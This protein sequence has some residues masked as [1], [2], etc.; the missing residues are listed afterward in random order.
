MRTHARWVKHSKT[1]CSL[2]VPKKSP[3]H[4]LAH[5]PVPRCCNCH[6]GSDSKLPP[7]CKRVAYSASTHNVHKKHPKNTTHFSFLHLQFFLW[8]YSECCWFEGEKEEDEKEEGSG[9]SEG[10]GAWGGGEG[11]GPFTAPF[12]PLRLL[13]SLQPV[14]HGRP[15]IYRIQSWLHYPW[16]LLPPLQ[17]LRQNRLPLHNV[18][19][20]Y[21]Q[22][23]HIDTDYHE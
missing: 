5:Q 11:G 4:H 17:C 2:S 16:T 6:W 18:A 19:I 23:Q 3:Y 15:G 12:N 21:S 20:K 22:T 13:I 9:C 1:C 14:D 10:L 8:N 7:S